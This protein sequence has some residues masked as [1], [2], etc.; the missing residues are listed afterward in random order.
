MGFEDGYNATDDSGDNI[1]SS[2]L[3]GVFGSIFD[4]ISMLI[5]GGE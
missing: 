4:F 2:I 3:Q 5:N 1:I